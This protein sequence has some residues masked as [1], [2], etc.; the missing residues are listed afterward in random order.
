[1]K[2]ID[3]RKINN[4]YKTFKQI[5]KEDKAFSDYKVKCKCSHVIIMT[6]V[7]DRVMCDH[8]GHYVYRD[9]KAEYKY[10]M[11]ELLK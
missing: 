6:S 5:E 3:D 11:K 8:C 10:K 7:K 9:K 4:R 2:D 1:M